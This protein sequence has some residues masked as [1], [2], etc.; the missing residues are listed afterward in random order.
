MSLTAELLN[1]KVDQ[2]LGQYDHM[3]F[4]EFSKLFLTKFDEYLKIYGVD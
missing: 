2:Y 3:D 1:E 4:D